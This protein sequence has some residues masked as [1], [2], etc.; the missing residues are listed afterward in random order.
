MA[1]EQQTVADVAEHS[2][3]GTPPPPPPP[4]TTRALAAAAA[5]PELRGVPLA[6]LRPLEGAEVVDAAV[7]LLRRNVRALG[8]L[9]AVLAAGRVVLLAV[10]ARLIPPSVAS[11]TDPTAGEIATAL[12][13]LLPLGFWF[14]LGSAAMVRVASD[15]MLG[16]TPDPAAAL[17]DA[18]RRVGAILYSHV[19]AYVLTGLVFAG[20]L[21]LAVLPIGIAVSAAG[22]LG[23]ALVGGAG[24][25]ACAGFTLAFYARYTVITPAVMIEGCG[26]REALRRSV[27]LTAASRRRVALLILV[28]MVI[29]LVATGGTGLLLKGMIDNQ[30]I[31]G[32]INTLL[33]MPLPALFAC[34][35]TVLYYDLRVRTE[36]YDIELMAG[37]LPAA[38]AA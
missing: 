4:P 22:S 14:F 2:A 8:V 30:Y 29:N 1:S 37:G 11:N 10:S 3:G 17:R 32:A 5:T 7:Q 26:P 15:A 19:E 36:G 6:A 24:L 38:P 18:L 25:L 16:R 21:L 20:T 12:G 13:S 31:A 23:A 35:L 33:W 9:A 27:A 28:V 34:V